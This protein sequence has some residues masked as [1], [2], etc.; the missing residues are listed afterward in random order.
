VKVVFVH[1]RAQEKKDLHELL[2]AWL[3]AANHGLIA[4]SYA[5][6]ASENAVLPYYGDLL[7]DLTEQASHAAF[8]DLVDKGAQSA[9][10]SGEELAFMQA[11]ILETA[12][13]K[14]ITLDQVAAQANEGVVEKDVQNWKIVL[15][16]LRLLDKIEGVGQTVVELRTRDVWVYLTQLGIRKRINDIVAAA[17]P[18][19]EPCIVVAHSL[20]TVVAY[21]VLM[22]RA[23]RANVKALFTIGSPLGIEAISSRLP[24]D[25]KPR[26]APSEIGTWFNARDAQD[27]VALYEIKQKSFPGLPEIQ[28]YTV[29]NNSS[30]HH[31]IERYLEDR[32]IAGAIGAAIA[33]G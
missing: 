22:L 11:I 32:T 24:S 13:A 9:A 4:L 17:I 33:S 20:G 2:E 23:S 12:L 14:G 10:P 6:I 26:K 7:F 27:T 28:N 1:G 18:D 25:I 19:T 8:N 29:V 3:T 31:D 15:A 21:N 30:N 5:P 16:A